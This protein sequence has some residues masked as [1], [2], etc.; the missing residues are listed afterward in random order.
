MERLVAGAGS[1]ATGSERTRSAYRRRSVPRAGRRSNGCSRSTGARPISGD[2]RDTH[3]G[4]ADE[5]LEMALVAVAPRLDP[6]VTPLD[7]PLTPVGSRRPPDCV[8]AQEE[9][10]AVVVAVRLGELLRRR[11]RGIGSVVAMRDEQHGVVAELLDEHP[12]VGVEGDVGVDP[13]ERRA[14]LQRLQRAPRRKPASASS[15]TRATAAPSAPRRRPGR[16]PPAPRRRGRSDLGSARAS[17][18]SFVSRSS[19]RTCSSRSGA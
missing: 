19:A 2:A 16:R 3:A 14:G 15:S 6:R 1:A 4:Q 9:G 11:G 5:L 7:R 10:S 8:G 13:E 17:S 12:R 18:S